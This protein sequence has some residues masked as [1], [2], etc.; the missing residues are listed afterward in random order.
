VYS[1]NFVT[2]DMFFIKPMLIHRYQILQVVVHSSNIAHPTIIL[3]VVAPAFLEYRCHVEKFL[4]IRITH[5]DKD[6]LKRRENRRAK[7]DAQFF[8]IRGG[9]PSGPAPLLT[10]S[11]SKILCNIIYSELK[12]TKRRHPVQDLVRDQK[13]SIHHQHISVHWIKSAKRL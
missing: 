13:A 10:S 6:L 3:D 11:S 9:M 8:R 12:S 5:L 1:N 7:A 2:V 4:R